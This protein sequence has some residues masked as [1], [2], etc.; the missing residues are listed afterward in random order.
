MLLHFKRVCS[1]VIDRFS[2]HVSDRD[3]NKYK[4]AANL[5]NDALAIR[6][7]TLGRDHPAVSAFPSVQSDLF[8]PAEWSI[9]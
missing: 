6:E 9:D 8:S 2:P 4:E 7:K 3:Q 5:L 1:S